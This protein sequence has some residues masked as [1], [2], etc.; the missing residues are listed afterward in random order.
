MGTLH[1]RRVRKCGTK[2]EKREGSSKR[3]EEVR[4]INKQGNHVNRI[5]GQDTDREE[6][7]KTNTQFCM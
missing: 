3:N 6:K 2:K 5:N 1:V 4:H 7:K